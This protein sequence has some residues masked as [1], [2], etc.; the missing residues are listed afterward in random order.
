M[1]NVETARGPIPTAE[2]GPTL[3]HEHVVTRS[4]GVQENWP[5]LWD[6]PGIVALAEQ[7][8]AE[9]YARGI[10]TI[11]DLTTVDLG[12]DIGLIAEVAKRSRVHIVVATGVW[13]MPQ[14]YFSAHGVDAVADLFIRDIRE[15]IGASGVKAAIIKCATDTAGVSP[16]IENILRASAR[17]QKA[18]GVPISTHTWAAGRVGETQQAIFAQEGVD[19]RRVIIGHSGDSEDLTYLR[20]L[21]ER[22]ST[23]GMDRFGLEHFLPTARRVEV[24]ARLCAEGYAA[25]MVLSHDANCWTDMLS[26]DDKRRTRPL[27]HYNHISDDILPLLRKAGVSEDHIDQMLVRNPR[28]IFE[29]GR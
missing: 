5:H 10:R 15:G 28:A 17:A 19:L 21:M 24:L 3:M 11:V 2:L 16:V 20:G 7:K 1:T 13:W 18:T 4:P 22:G 14:R 12:R 29:G 8:L 27:W 26:E 6:R 9:L 25:R 23:I